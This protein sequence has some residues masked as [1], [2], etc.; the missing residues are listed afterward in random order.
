MCSSLVVEVN[1]SMKVTI[2]LHLCWFIVTLTKCFCSGCAF[3][4]LFFSTDFALIL[5]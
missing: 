5:C 4:S 1:G 2:T 3:G